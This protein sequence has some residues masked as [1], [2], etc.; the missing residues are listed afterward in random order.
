[1]EQKQYL[2]EREVAKLTG[3]SVYTLRNNRFKGVGFQYVKIGKSVRYDLDAV[4]KFMAAHTIKTANQTDL[5][6][7]SNQK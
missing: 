3:F 1:M 6:A 2:N 4:L 5:S 7:I